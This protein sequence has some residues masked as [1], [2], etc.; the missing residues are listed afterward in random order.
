M[1][2]IQERVKAEGHP[3]GQTESLTDRIK[4]LIREYPEGIGII[5]E[6]IQN[7]DDAGARK[8]H[9]LIDW[10]RHPQEGLPEGMKKLQGPALLAYN[11]AVFPRNDFTHIQTIGISG[12]ARTAEKTGRF[13]LGFNA[14][15]NLTDW[16]GFFTA[17]TGPGAAADCLGEPRIAFFDPN[18]SAIEGAT[19]QQP[20]GWWELERCREHFPGLL[21][22]FEAALP[23]G[24]R[25]LEDCPGT[26]FRFPLRTARHA[27]DSRISNKPVEQGSLEVILAKLGEAGEELF[28]FLKCLEEFKVLGVCPSIA[29]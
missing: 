27:P 26:I 21:A 12:K 5:K 14:V 4:G 10:R 1:S 2:S 22:S 15:Y 11:D 8:L 29:F 20:G 18:L 6:V 25:R 3:F 28:L 16:P 9:I 23:D 13:G 17:G 24:V 19:P 7:A